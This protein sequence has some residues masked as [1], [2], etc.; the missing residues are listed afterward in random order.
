MRFGHPY[1]GLLEEYERVFEC[2]VRFGQPH[3]AMVIGEDLWQLRLEIW[4]PVLSERL[5][6]LAAEL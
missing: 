4:D 2:P 6:S 3:T 1:R 5:E